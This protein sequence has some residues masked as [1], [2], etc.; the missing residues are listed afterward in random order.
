[1][2][3]FKV[4]QKGKLSQY[5]KPFTPLKSQAGLSNTQTKC[6]PIIKTL[7]NPIT[8]QTAGKINSNEDTYYSMS[9]K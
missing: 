7:N 5:Q 3:S 8:L 1:M 2:K 4:Q 6:T 9:L